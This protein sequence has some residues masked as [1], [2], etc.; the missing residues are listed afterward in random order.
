MTI[1]TGASDDLIEIDGDLIDEFDAY[2]CTDGRMVISDGTLLKV[3]YDEDGIWRFKVLY[4]GTLFDHKDEGSVNE[5]TNDIVHFMPGIK[6]AVFAK[7]MQIASY[8]VVE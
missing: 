5:D 6:W 2:D 3:E 8:S 4:K 7:K 1:V